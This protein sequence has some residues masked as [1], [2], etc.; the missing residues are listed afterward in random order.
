MIQVWGGTSIWTH[1]LVQDDYVG[2]VV[3]HVFALN[4]DND[5]TMLLFSL[6]T[7]LTV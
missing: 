4:A 5:N 7:F 2:N 3:E 1:H 6:L